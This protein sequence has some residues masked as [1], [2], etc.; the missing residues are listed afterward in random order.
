VERIA[1]AVAR[2]HVETGAPITVHTSGPAQSGRL[3]VDLF[4]KEGVDLTKVVI[5]HAGESNDLAY[6]MELADSAMLGMDRF[7]LDIFNPTADRVRTVAA[8]AERGYTDR[9]VLAH[10]ASCFIDYFGAALD[11]VH[12][13]AAPNWHFEHISDDVLPALRESGVSDEQIR[14]MLVSR[15]AA[16]R[17]CG[18]ATCGTGRR[19]WPVAYGPRVS[20][21]GTGWRSTSVTGSTGHWRSSAPSSR[22]ASWCQSIPGSPTTR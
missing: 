5:G 14:Q 10:D 13:A 1:R 21:A 16:A 8:L 9:M 4:T 18:T 11:A 20:G 2:T 3:A 12:A 17:G 19:G 7:G 15:P 6:L 22:A